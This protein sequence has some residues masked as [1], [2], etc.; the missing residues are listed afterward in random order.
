MIKIIISG[1]SDG[2]YPRYA[3]DGVLNDDISNHLV[4]RRDY[5][6]KEVDRLSREGYSFQLLAKGVLFHKIIPLF[7]AFGRDGFMMASLY[8]PDGEKLKGTE[9]KEALDAIIREYKMHIVGGMAN[10]ELD[11]SFVKRKADEVNKKVNPDAWRRHPSPTN[12]SRTALMKGADNR[13]AEYFEYPNP[14]LDG[15]SGYEQVFLTE[16]LLDPALE[17]SDGDQGYKVLTKDDVDIDNPTYVIDYINPNGYSTK[18]LKHEVTKKELDAPGSFLCGELSKD[19]YRKQI[20]LISEGKKQSQDG[21]TIKVELPTL[22]PKQASVLLKVVDSNTGTEIPWGNY[23]VSWKGSQ[24]YD[25]AWGVR[26][27][28][29]PLFNFEKEECDQTWEVSVECEQYDKTETTVNTTDGKMNIPVLITM[30]YNPTWTI[31]VISPVNTIQ[32]PTKQD[33]KYSE[34][35]RIKENLENEGLKVIISPEDAVSRIIYVTAKYPELKIKIFLGLQNAQKMKEETVTSNELEKKIEQLK[36]DWRDK[37]L[38]FAKRD[39]SE[40]IVKLYFVNRQQSNSASLANNL[41]TENAM[42]SSNYGI[43]TESQKESDKKKWILKLNSGSKQYSLFK[44]YKSRKNKADD[45][46]ANLDKV[47]NQ[48]TNDDAIKSSVS[49]ILQHLKKGEIDEALNEYDSIP[50]KTIKTDK[51]RNLVDSS[52]DA[53]KDCNKFKKTPKVVTKPDNVSYFSEK[54]SHRLEVCSEKKPED[55]IELGQDRYSYRLESCHWVSENETQSS[56]SNKVKRT[57]RPV[58]KVLWFVLPLIVIGGAG[59]AWY[60]GFRESPVNNEIEDLTTRLEVA[61]DSL[62]NYKTYY[63]DDTL[64]NKYYKLPLEYSTIN[65]KNKKKTGSQEMRKL[66]SVYGVFAGLF[67]D[68]KEFKKK[69]AAIYA[70][71]KFLDKPLDSWSDIERFEWDTLTMEEKQF[72][73]QA[74]NTKITVMSKKHQL[75]VLQW[76]ETQ[77][78]AWADKEDEELFNKINGPNTCQVYLNI[79]PKGIHAEEANAVNVFFKKKTCDNAKAYM[80][81]YPNGNFV[82]IVQNWINGNCGGTTQSLQLTEGHTTET[83]EKKETPK[84]GN[85]SGKTP[86]TNSQAVFDAL[87]WDVV[88]SGMES[89]KAKYVLSQEMSSKYYR[90]IISIVTS[91][92]EKKDKGELIKEEYEKIHGEANNEQN[93]ADKITKLEKKIGLK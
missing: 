67:E 34:L 17:S 45:A 43:D 52:Y 9:I 22:V 35:E 6:S 75:E 76:Y 53:I 39:G 2:F 65:N 8:L 83:P 86:L 19:G 81:Q 40:G 68:Q 29:S 77:K 64:F 20:V 21:E 49:T 72:G 48:Y 66:D 60:F 74:N 42:S 36:K 31:S 84:N 28:Q 70:E 54:N 15:F 4:D 89:F 91:V 44:N 30:K 69:D 12:I 93:P 92:R 50:E 55:K 63:C 26:S 32:Y 27:S 71:L 14:L 11:W 38:E 1:T 58:Y 79:F 10:V 73:Q 16:R 47:F 5:L 41:R 37:G 24:Y 25:S 88:T 51:A 62:N 33:K 85:N 13:I 46:I 57:L 82:N 18:N 3:S 61:I 87:T 7:D 90:R 78:K 80:E 59:A 23:S 56:K